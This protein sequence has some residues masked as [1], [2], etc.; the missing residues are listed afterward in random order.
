MRVNYFLNH[1]CVGYI[2][3]APEC[4][5]Y[6][7]Y[8]GDCLHCFAGDECYCNGGRGHSEFIEKFI[9]DREFD[10]IKLLE[11]FTPYNN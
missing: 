3:R 9:N 11:G 7:E 6:C 2:N 8:C 4:G 5:D 10:E 1:V